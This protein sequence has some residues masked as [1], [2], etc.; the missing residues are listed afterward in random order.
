MSATLDRTTQSVLPPQPARAPSAGGRLFAVHPPEV[1]GVIRL[2]A[3]RCTLGRESEPAGVP[4]L[5]HPTVSRRHVEVEWDAAAGTHRVRDLG[6]HNGSRLDGERL[7]EA[8]V[9]MAPGALLRVA[10]VLLTYE[11]CTDIGDAPG[12]SLE[13]LPGRSFAAQHLR[14]A[15]ARIAPELTPALLVG[16]T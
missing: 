12:V 4:P 10:D 13:A 9:P 11:R 2:P 7:S 14:A 6:S 5:R 8:I 16:E 1:V 15:I 3:G